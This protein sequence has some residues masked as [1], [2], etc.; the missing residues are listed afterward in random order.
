MTRADKILCAVYGVTAL[1]A[2]VATWWHNVAFILSGQGRSITDFIAAA[3]ANHAAASLTNDVVLV[4][5]A[6]AVFM[7][8]EARRLGIAHVWAYLVMSVFIAI[9]VAFPVFLIVRQVVLARGRPSG[10]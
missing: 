7:V 3:Y 2:L 9:S 4:A 5:V 8:V 10:S 6:A 1:V